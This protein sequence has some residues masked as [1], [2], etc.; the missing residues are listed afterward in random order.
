MPDLSIAL[1][2]TNV[3][4]PVAD[5]ADWLALVDNRLARAG[6]ARVDL[7][8]MP[9]YAIAQCMG[10]MPD[11]L[12]ASQQIPWFAAV[13]EGI[14][15]ALCRL[16]GK[17]RT[18]LLCG[19]MPVSDGRGGY[20]NRAHLILPAEGGGASVAVT[21]D[22]LCLTLAERD[23]GG[24]LMTAGTTLRVVDWR[25]LRLAIL[26]GLDVEQ[27][28]LA[29]RL[30]SLSPDLLLVPALT[31]TPSGFN[32]VFGC[33]RARAIELETIVAVVGAI[34][35]TR[36]GSTNFSAAAVYAPCEELLGSDG[37]LSYVPPR[38]DVDGAGPMLI[39]RFLPLETLRVLRDG[40]SEEWPGPWAPDRLI[41]ETG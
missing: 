38:G 15:P 10:F 37:V 16:V 18:A 33:A 29:A 14:V 1:W 7:L 13:A 26:I 22:K 2:A 35:T 30:A 5:A 12:S 17:H 34:G 36:D 3:A 8:V 11:G 24:W 41:I 6:A 31:R 4:K 27:P 9:E 28:T 19:T 23:P 25:G 40:A 39:S 21:Q 20:L 32:R